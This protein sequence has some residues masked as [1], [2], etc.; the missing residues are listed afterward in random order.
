M[1]T[2]TTMGSVSGHLAKPSGSGPWPA[3]IVIQEWWGLDDQT[4]SIADRFAVEG[5][6]AFAPDLY[7]GELAKLGDHQ[8]AMGLAQKYGPGAPAELQKLYDALKK[9]SDCSGKIGSVGFCFGGRMSLALGIGRPLNAI[10]T[11]YGGGM[12]QLF[13]QLGKI[14]CPVLGLFG[15]QDQSIPVGTV[16]QFEKLL[17]QLG[18]EHEIKVYPNSGHAFFRDSDPNVFKPEA[19][20]DAWERVRKF[21][22][23]NLL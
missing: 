17:T 6:L 2:L 14:K 18:I 16:D 11:F 13:D 21:F 22:A 7:H 1:T 4:K 10:C 5:Y 8:T 3:V 20:K 9:H 19:A 12:Q 15:D 23:A